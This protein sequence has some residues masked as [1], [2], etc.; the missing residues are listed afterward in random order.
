[1]LQHV[2]ETNAPNSLRQKILQGLHQTHDPC[3]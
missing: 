3:V 1:M 2:C